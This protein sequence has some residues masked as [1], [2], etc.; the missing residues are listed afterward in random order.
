MK[1]YFLIICALISF[2]ILL[3]GCI[4]APK[5]PLV[6]QWQRIE[7]DTIYNNL[8]VN[9]EA[10][11]DG[12]RAVIIEMSPEMEAAGYHIGDTKWK[13]VNKLK[14][15]LYEYEDLGKLFATKE[16]QWY[17]MNLNMDM[18]NP[19]VINMTSVANT[20]EIGSNQQWKRV[21]P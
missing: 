10:L 8:I 11:D 21:L 12:Y 13:N 18:K 1:R 4:N 19:D 2:A 14:E 7:P 17:D 15:G 6:G 3:T 9:V 16:T 5:D 20:G